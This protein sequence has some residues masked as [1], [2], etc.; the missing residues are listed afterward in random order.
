MPNNGANPAEAAQAAMLPALL[1]AI[2]QNPGL[3]AAYGQH[4]G[5]FAA[6]AQSTGLLATPQQGG[7]SFAV[8]APVLPRIAI[9][10]APQ[11]YRKSS[12]PIGVAQGYTQNHEH[13]QR[14]RARFQGLAYAHDLNTKGAIKANLI[15]LPAGRLRGDSLGVSELVQYMPVLI[16]F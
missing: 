16:T 7:G 11:S 8:P 4:P 2:G 14:D 3:L 15:I 1:A 13:Y 5:P 12:N 9:P 6:R 10:G